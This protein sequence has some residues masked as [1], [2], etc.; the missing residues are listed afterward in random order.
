M[1]NQNL[2]I[3]SR[4]AS[5]ANRD[6]TGDLLL[7]KRPLARPIPALK[8]ADLQGFPVTCRGAKIGADSRGL[9]AIIVVSGTFGDKVPGRSPLSRRSL[10]V[11]RARA[12]EG[13]SCVVVRPLCA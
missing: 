12:K 6:R 4:F 1:A 2:P 5:G 11:W 9:S 7:A 13:W 10:G 8:G 3:C